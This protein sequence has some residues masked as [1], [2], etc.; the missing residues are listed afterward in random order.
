MRPTERLKGKI[1]IE[2][3]WL[4]ILHSLSRKPM[5]GKGLKALIYD[6]FD[7]VTGTVTAYKVL[8]S[9]EAGGYVV[10]KRDGKYVTYTITKKGKG[11]LSKGK[12]MLADYARRL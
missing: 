12:A 3:L 10:A 5:S 2:N 8:Y 11:E 7:F 1:E 9:L 4:F 6:R